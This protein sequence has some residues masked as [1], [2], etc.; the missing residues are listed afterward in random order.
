M[1]DTATV[2]LLS[3]LMNKSHKENYKLQAKVEDKVGTL[4]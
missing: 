3:C 2:D 4:S 1:P